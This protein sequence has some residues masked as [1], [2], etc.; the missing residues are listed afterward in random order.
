MNLR[1]EE[2]VGGRAAVVRRARNLL[3]EPPP[4]GT[5]DLFAAHGNLGR[6]S[7]SLYSSEG[8]FMVIAPRGNWQLEVID[9]LSLDELQSTADE[10][11]V[12]LRRSDAAAE[13]A[14][15]IAGCLQIPYRE[16]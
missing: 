12:K 7:F 15:S 6:A 11:D 1:V 13:P 10:S 9:T 16:F 8:E 14:G 2:L 4:A 5:N 3:S